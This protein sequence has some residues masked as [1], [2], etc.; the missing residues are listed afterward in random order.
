MPNHEKWSHLWTVHTSCLLTNPLKRFM[1]TFSRCLDAGKLK[2]G[3]NLIV[4]PCLDS[5]PYLFWRK[6][7]TQSHSAKFL[8]WGD[9]VNSVP[10][11]AASPPPPPDKNASWMLSM[12]DF[13][14]ESPVC[15]QR[16]TERLWILNLFSA[17]T[18]LWASRFD[19]LKDHNFWTFQ[20][21]FVS[22]KNPVSCARELYRLLPATMLSSFS[23]S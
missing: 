3:Q 16:F 2:T 7:G 19:W 13:F 14:L 5:P 4:L 6:I 11:L 9:H 18:G 20:M 10:D 23:L 8:I 21:L 1:K 17:N 12:G 22:S 15:A